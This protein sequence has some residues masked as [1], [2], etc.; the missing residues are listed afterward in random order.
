LNQASGSQFFLISEYEVFPVAGDSAVWLGDNRRLLFH[1]TGRILLLD[2]KT[3]SFR[4]V[5]SLE[6]EAVGQYLDLSS[7][8]RTIY[9]RR[10]RTEADIWM[11]TLGYDQQ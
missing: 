7:D 2:V 4:E 3:G 5:L 9:F 6:P 10:I 11:V 1:N 8:D